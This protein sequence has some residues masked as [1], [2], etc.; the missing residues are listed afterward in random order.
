RDSR[1]RDAQLT[2]LDF[3]NVD[4]VDPPAQTFEVA[5]PPEYWARLALEDMYDRVKHLPDD[6]PQLETVLGALD[7]ARGEPRV[8]RTG[9]PWA[10]FNSVVEHFKTG[11][12][13]QAGD[14]VGLMSWVSDKSNSNPIWG[15]GTK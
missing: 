13:T 1:L 4:R 6:H 3:T 11:G 14:V 15:S 5:P 12:S 9:A 7:I 2:P 10:L 8:G